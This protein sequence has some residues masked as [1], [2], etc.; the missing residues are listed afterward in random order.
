[1]PGRVIVDQP[2]P[3]IPMDGFGRM[4]MQP[5]FPG[6]GPQGPE[7]RVPFIPPGSRSPTPPGEPIENIK[8]IISS[9]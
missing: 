3:V 8:L 5:G 9:H 7:Q 2:G 6:P 4:G 1:M